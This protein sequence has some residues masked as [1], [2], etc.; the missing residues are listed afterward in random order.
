VGEHPVIVDDQ[1]EVTVGS[2]SI[3]RLQGFKF[4]VDP[5]AKHAD[6]KMLLATAER[7]L[8]TEFEKRAA[9]LVADTDDHFTCAARR[10]CRPQSCGAAM[11]WRG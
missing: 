2:Y 3:G 4:E 11:R 7:R 10:G 9:A 1:G 5:S 8:G 6:R